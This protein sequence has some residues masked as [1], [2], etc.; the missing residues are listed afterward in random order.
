MTD[1][2]TTKP[3]TIIY[4]LPKEILP[5]THYAQATGYVDL[6]ELFKANRKGESFA[7]EHCEFLSERKHRNDVLSQYRSIH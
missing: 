5:N 3:R 1:N 4:D 2:A 7:F 6:G